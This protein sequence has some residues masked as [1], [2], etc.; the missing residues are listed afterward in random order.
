M[1]EILIEIAKNLGLI[2]LIFFLVLIL[3]GTISGI[4]STLT[5]NKRKEKIKNDLEDIV[6]KIKETRDSE[7]KED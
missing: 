4:I 6:N 5:E 2:T 3:L 1:T 7:K